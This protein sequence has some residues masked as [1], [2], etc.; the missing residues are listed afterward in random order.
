MAKTLEPDRVA[1]FLELVL[2]GASSAGAAAAAGSA[3]F[4]DAFLLFFFFSFTSSACMVGERKREK[5]RCRVITKN[6]IGKK[7][8][9]R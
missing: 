4:S 9:G 7:K 5:M 1:R 6:R 8:V 2:A 3:A